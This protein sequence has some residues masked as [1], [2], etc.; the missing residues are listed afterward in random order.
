MRIAKESQ[1]HYTAIIS[2]IEEVD[3]KAVESTHIHTRLL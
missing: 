3:T 1:A 2:D